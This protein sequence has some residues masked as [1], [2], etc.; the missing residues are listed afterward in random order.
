MLCKREIF[1]IS[2]V[3]WPKNLQQVTCLM[4]VHKTAE[5]ICHPTSVLLP[6]FQVNNWYGTPCCFA[7]WL[8]HSAANWPSLT[9]TKVARVKMPVPVLTVTPII[10]PSPPAPHALTWS[11]HRY[12]VANGHFYE[13]K[14]ER[15]GHWMSPQRTPCSPI[16]WSLL[17]LRWWFRGTL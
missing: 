4:G 16:N 3:V 14:Q 10:S 15:V 6:V 17:D 11:S 8:H 7:R 9:Q 5:S 12:R 1:I 2:H 13:S